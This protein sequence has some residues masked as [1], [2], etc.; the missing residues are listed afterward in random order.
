MNNFFVICFGFIILSTCVAEP[1]IHK[2]KSA[3][4]GYTLYPDQSDNTAQCTDDGKLCIGT[5]Y[6]AENWDHLAELGVTH[7]VS[8]IGEPTRGPYP[9]AK[10]LQLNLADN[11][12]QQMDLAFQ[13][14]YDF[15][16]KAFES[17]DAVV[18]VHC[19]AGVSRS[20]SIIIHY[21]MKEYGMTYQQ[22]YDKLKAI[23]HVIQ[24]N[25]GFV[26]QLTKNEKQEL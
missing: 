7:I 17:K 23:R 19:A 25:P 6:A 5:W 22:A 16:H 4:G 2:S 11:Q 26:S 20:S 18:L 21:W 13:L 12:Y 10:Y 1:F 9:Y 8:A 15:I 14:S 3:A 24:P